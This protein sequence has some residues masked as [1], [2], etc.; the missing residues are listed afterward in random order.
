MPF[1]FQKREF[2]I[3]MELR[4]GAIIPDDINMVLIVKVSERRSAP[5]TIKELVFVMIFVK[6]LTIALPTVTWPP[7]FAWYWS[8][9][10]ERAVGPAV[11]CCTCPLLPGPS[12]V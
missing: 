11:T 9:M 10:D 4:E 2:G 5:P 7:I 1:G 12:S 3:W 8:V 6:E